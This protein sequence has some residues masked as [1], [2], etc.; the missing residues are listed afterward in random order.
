MKQALLFTVAVLALASCKGVTDEPATTGEPVAAEVTAHIGPVS[1]VSGTSWD[2]GDRIGI[3]GVSGTKAYINTEY[4]VADRAKGSFSAVGSGIFYQ[5]PAEVT[6]TAYYPYTAS[7]IAGKEPVITG[8]TR[9]AAQS[10]AS[11]SGIDYLWAQAAGSYKKEVNFSFEH[12]MSRLS[13]AFTAGAD[14]NLSELTSYTVHGLK[15]EG[16]FDTATGIA[17]ATGAPEPLTISNPAL[18]SLILY[19]QATGG[20]VKISAV[21]SSQTYS[22]NLNITELKAGM[23]Y[24][25]SIKVSK[26]GLT[27]TSGTISDWGDGG[28]FGGNA[29]MPIP[30]RKGDFFYSDGTYSTQ[31]DAAKTCIGIVFWTPADANPDPA[32]KTPASLT[33]DKIMNADFPDC[34][35]GLVVA[36][37]DCSEQVEWMKDY[38]YNIYNEFQSKDY[39]MPSN[40]DKYR[41]IACGTDKTDELNYIL[42]YQNTK[43]LKAY[44]E[45]ND[46]SAPEISVLQSLEGF[47][48]QNPAPKNT[49]G[50]FVP[51][52]K[53]LCLLVNIDQDNVYMVRADETHRNYINNQLKNVN[54]TELGRTL[55]SSTEVS[56]ERMTYQGMAYALFSQYYIN[57][58]RKIYKFSLRPILAF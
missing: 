44:K 15:M 17:T 16:T 57:L 48:S 26:T 37:N 1:R 46:G 51:S 20:S 21:V 9:A 47:S 19:P 13:L 40:K 41:P 22:C 39:F 28:S 6:F 4:R 27:V 12:R 52:A 29:T 38:D 30:A 23:D 18:T 43:I 55:W 33:D 5:T 34:T 32:A 25:I 45:W 53:E 54:G 49:T 14:I 58:Q 50:W 35:H 2:E 24:T 56:T 10:A 36:L 31:L 3:S 11:Q 7:P 42:G 8:N